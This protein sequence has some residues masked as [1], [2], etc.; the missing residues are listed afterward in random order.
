MLLDVLPEDVLTD[1]IFVLF[2]DPWPKLRHHKHRILQD[3]FLE[4]L[5]AKT[6]PGA[7]LCFRTDFEPY[8][9]DVAAMLKTHRDWALAED[10]W[11]FELPTVFQQRAATY[12]SLIARRR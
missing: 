6:L 8:F 9:L 5:A 1:L 2:P 11:P 3:P 4:R 10:T 12:H 7:R